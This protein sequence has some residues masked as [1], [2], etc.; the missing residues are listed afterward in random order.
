MKENL[1][2]YDDIVY[3]ETTEFYSYAYV[4][5]VISPVPQVLMQP[6]RTNLLTYSRDLTNAAWAE[7][8]T[9]VA[10]L[11]AVGM[12]GVTNSVCTLTD[13]D[14]AGYESTTHSATI[15]S[16]TSTHTCRIFVEKDTEQNRFPEVAVRLTG[17]SFQRI[18]FQ[19][20]TETGASTIRGTNATSSAEVSDAGS[21]WEVL[22]SV[23]DNNTGNVNFNVDIFP[24]RGDTLGN[25]S[26]AATGSII[27]GNVELHE[28]K[29][30]EEVRGTSPIFTGAAAVTVDNDLIEIGDALAWAPT[31][32]VAVFAFTPQVDWGANLAEEHLASMG[33]SADARL[34]YRRVNKDGLASYPPLT[35]RLSGN[36]SGEEV[37]VSVIWSEALNVSTIGYSQSG[38]GF[39]WDFTPGVY[40]AKTYADILEIGRTLA[41]AI[42]VRSLLIYDGLPTGADASLADVQAWVEANSEAEILKRQA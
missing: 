38:A 12:D 22:A 23:T 30:I 27:V 15:S 26:V 3:D 21:Y 33:A 39:G 10:A 18:E 1:D 8:G 29:T 36:T 17:G 13:D 2:Y 14:G 35:E 32:L 7:T 4:S 37:I 31:S 40:Q 5:T 6:Q 11:D 19:I 9:S 42:G 34:V 28:N 41:G 16:G 20:N 24:A 25:L